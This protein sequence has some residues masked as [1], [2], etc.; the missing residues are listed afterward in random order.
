MDV[1][2]IR[3]NIPQQV[4]LS[5]RPQVYGRRERSRQ[6]FLRGPIPLSWLSH[7][8]AARGSAVA[9]GLSLWFMRGVAPASPDIKVTRAV[10]RRLGLSQDQMHRGLLRLQSV[11]LVEFVSRGR[12][13][14]PVVRIVG[15]SLVAPDRHAQEPPNAPVSK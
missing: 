3:I 4:E 15:E 6:P 12:G 10:R 5:L 1:E 9:V 14:C 7:A 13:R 11:G 8:I 2:Q